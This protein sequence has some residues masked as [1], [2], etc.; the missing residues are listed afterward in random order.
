MMD[1]PTPEYR[2]N[3]TVGEGDKYT[4][5]QTEEGRLKA[6]RYGKEW[7][8]CWGDGLIFTLAAEVETLREEMAKRSTP[9]AES[10]GFVAVEPPPFVAMTRNVITNVM[11]NMIEMDALLDLY[12]VVENPHTSN[13]IL[14]DRLKAALRHET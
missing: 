4:V 14:I 7:R 2:L 13:S 3:V 5:Y 9:G 10:T 1:A 6:R 12:G 11:T 8:D